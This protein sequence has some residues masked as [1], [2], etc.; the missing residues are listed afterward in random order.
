MKS[1][2]KRTRMTPKPGKWCK[3]RCKKFRAKRPRSGARYASGQALCRVCAMFIT[4]EGIRDHRCLCCH[5]KVR[6]S[7][8]G[9]KFKAA[10]RAA[11]G[12]LSVGIP[13]PELAGVPAAR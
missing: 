9:K 6:T 5:F 8:R 3:G 12:R 11:A 7:P 4:P 13:G 2:K 10:F 1:C